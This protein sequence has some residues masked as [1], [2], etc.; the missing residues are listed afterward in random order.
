MEIFR[1][2]DVIGR[3]G[4]PIKAHVL[5]SRPDTGVFIYRPK[6]LLSPAMKLYETK[7]ILRP[8]AK[9]YCAELDERMLLFTAQHGGLSV[10]T[11][12]PKMLYPFLNFCMY[13]VSSN[14]VY[15]NP[16]FLTTDGKNI[17]CSDY[18]KVMSDINTP[19]IKELLREGFCPHDIHTMLML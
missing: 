18:F 13:Y 2:E 10:P 16:Q 3:R 7:E 8:T 11:Y 4:S 14:K 5:F 1:I 19:K 15:K 17:F 12:E 9:E 6:S